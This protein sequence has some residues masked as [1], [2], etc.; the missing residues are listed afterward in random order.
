MKKYLLLAVCL[1]L[2]FCLTACAGAEEEPLLLEEPV[3]EDVM[4]EEE[5]VLSPEE[6]YI[7]IWSSD[8][9]GEKEPLRL[10]FFENG[11]AF[12][13]GRQ[14]IGLGTWMIK[15]NGQL[16]ARFEYCYTADPELTWKL[17]P[18]GDLPGLML[19]ET[20][21][22]ILLVSDYSTQ[23]IYKEAKQYHPVNKGNDYIACLEQ[24]DAYYGED[25]GAWLL[26]DGANQMRK[27]IVP[28]YSGLELL[29]YR[30]LLEVLP[31]TEKALLINQEL[32]WYGKKQERV[33]TAS[34]A[35]REDIACS[36]ERIEE[37]LSWM[38]GKIPV[39]SP[40]EDGQ[41]I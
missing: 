17:L 28:V 8:E 33:E 1:F 21:G 30:C 25:M 18:K 5:H 20:E 39:Y 6:Q 11:S 24:L 31:E 38:R 13:F 10:C 9:N 19:A 22:D 32:V 27:V 34:F 29:M 35:E 4:P 7:G 37:L 41:L 36:R 12:Q 40:S 26:I 14:T 15:D 16:S 3:A 2:L 23:G